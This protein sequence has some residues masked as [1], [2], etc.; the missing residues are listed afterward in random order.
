[1]EDE[2]KEDSEVLKEEVMEE[3]QGKG[4]DEEEI[5]KNSAIKEPPEPEVVP[6]GDVVQ[7]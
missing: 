2:N 4:S 1:M 7:R 6:V 5:K 3:A